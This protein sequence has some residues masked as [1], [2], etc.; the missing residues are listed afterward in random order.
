MSG[1]RLRLIAVIA[2]AAAAL[3]VVAVVAV[4]TVLPKLTGTLS[5]KRSPQP[6]SSGQTALPFGN[7]HL[8]AGNSGSGIAVDGAGAV[9]VADTGNGRI[10]KL[11][12][13]AS[14]PTS[15]SF[16]A[17]DKP[18]GVAVDSVGAVYAIQGELA[19]SR[20]A[21]LSPV[22]R[23]QSSCQLVGRS[24]VDWRSTRAVGCM[25]PASN[26]SKG[27]RRNGRSFEQLPQPPGGIPGSVAVDAAGAVYVLV[28]DSVTSDNRVYHIQKLAAGATGYTDLTPAGLRSKG[29]MH[30]LAL[31]S[32]GAV[33]FTGVDQVSK[34]AAGTGAPVKLP[35]TGLMDPYGIAIGTDGTVY[36]S[37]NAGGRVMKLGPSG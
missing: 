19:G 27:W 20:L 21:K 5:P 1:K 6:S 37:D 28:D 10:L 4:T 8:V 11:A 24:T 9:Y 17:L 36:V 30:L 29:A 31:D 35:F 3:C 7:L 2:A 15:L 26:R 34:L 33:Y 18:S 22:L 16:P 14:E 13:G 23:R 25:W 32:A 12:E